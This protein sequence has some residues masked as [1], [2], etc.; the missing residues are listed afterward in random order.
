MKELLCA[1]IIAL[2]PSAAA[3]QKQEKVGD[4]A[5]LEIIKSTRRPSTWA[6]ATVSLQ[7]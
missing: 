4:N 3:A 7:R 2:L 1:L 5:D 6:T